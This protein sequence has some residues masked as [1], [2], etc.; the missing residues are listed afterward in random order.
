MRRTLFFLLILPFY[1]LA[2]NNFPPIGQWREHLPYQGV[3]D[4]TS[5]QNRIYAATP[6]SFFSIDIATKEITRYSKV[7]GLSETGVSTIKFDPVSKKL[8]IAYNNS[9]ID[10]MD[11]KGIHNIPDFKREN[12]AGDKNI[13]HLFPDNNRVYLSTGIGIIVLDA[14]K[15]EIHDSWFIGNNGGYVKVN[16]FVKN[17]NFFYAATEEGLKKIATTNSNPADFTNWQ[18]VS[19]SG[20]LPLSPAR[21]VA[22][23]GG[24]TIVLQNDSLFVENAGTWSPFFQNGWPVLSINVSENKLF[25]NQRQNNGSAQIVVLDANGAVLQ[26]MQN[27]GLISF[28]K[29]AISVQNEIWIADLFGGLSHWQGSNFELYKLNSPVDVAL[30]GMTVYNNQLYA[31]AGAV[32]DSWNY[33]YNRGGIFKFSSGSWTIYNQY[34]SSRLDT[35]MDFISVAVDPR[36]ESLWAGSFG[37]GL[38][39]LKID[40]TLDIFKQNSPIGST[41]GDPTSYRVAG[42]AFDYEQNLWISNF[43]SP[44]QLHVLKNDGSWQSFTAP[45]FINQNA[46]AQIVI[47]DANFK[48]IQSPLGNG[49]L[50]FDHNNTIDNPADDRWRM[51]RQG[52]GNGNLPSNY[53]MSLAKDK[54][55]FIWVG[56]D[57]GIAVLQCPQDVFNNGCEAI[58]PVIKEGSFANYLFKGQEVRGIAV[59][60]ADRKWIATSSGAWL[61]SPDGDQ[62]IEHFT[63]TNSALL[64]N[65]I[66]SVTINGLT[67]E[68]FFATSK[69]I[70]SFRG[71]ATEAAE[72]KRKVLVFPNPVAPDYNG[73]I[74][75]RGLPENSIVKI[76][77][78]NG[79]LV[80]QGRSLGGQV[81][82]NGYD[83]KGEK[84][85]S[86]VYLVIAVDNLREEKVVGK[87]VFISSR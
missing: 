8:Y 26:V 77:E 13:Y 45:F 40:N 83:Y 74:G 73:S 71:A 43:G 27:A 28:P 17:N 53:V 59:D 39:H 4:V 76:T 54:S 7:S 68:V 25:V 46:V 61:V 44:Q 84:V 6:F 85:S 41:V 51:L 15:Y 16:A 37:G 70:S 55:G 9:N 38:L 64:S 31:T 52:A 63:E 20:G 22:S 80:F 2:Q 48:W 30:G 56:T 67:G 32:N 47:D 78:T 81:T 65:D 86:G 60:G 23:L 21:G 82:W 69:G 42:L 62:V 35:L 66:R 34:Y 36:D 24:K 18:T 5:S 57:N 11:E 12:I 14:E 75:I 33:Q 49:L 58:W 3:V 29:N 50:V 72:T 19:G 1:A 79:R 87:I 10:V